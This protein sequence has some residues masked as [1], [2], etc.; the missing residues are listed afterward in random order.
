MRKILARF[1]GVIWTALL[2]LVAGSAAFI[3]AVAGASSEIVLGLG[4]YGLI[5]AT[6]SPKS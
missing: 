1:D 6:L 2:S 5:L 3:S 4:L